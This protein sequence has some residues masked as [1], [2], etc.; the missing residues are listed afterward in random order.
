MHKC[1]NKNSVKP[2]KLELMKHKKQVVHY[3]SYQ[4]EIGKFT[5]NIVS[6]NVSPEK[7]VGDSKSLLSP[8][9]IS[10]N[11]KIETIELSVEI[12]HLVL[13]NQFGLHVLSDSLILKKNQIFS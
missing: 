4:Q 6:G 7:R 13:A 8:T 1:I 12:F 11:I 3:K 9:C 10:S 5:D 2:L